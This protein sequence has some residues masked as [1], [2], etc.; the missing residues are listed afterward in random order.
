M[1]ERAAMDGLLT[2]LAASGIRHCTSMYADNATM[3]IRPTRVDMLTYVGIVED[4][5]ASSGL[6]LT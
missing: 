4:F 5:R 1:I 6:A 3:F 2:E